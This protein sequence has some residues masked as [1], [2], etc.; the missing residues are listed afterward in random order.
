MTEQPPEFGNLSR[1][2]GAVEVHVLPEGV[3]LLDAA[4]IQPGEQPGDHLV[5]LFACR[6]SPPS[7]IE[8][9]IRGEYPA[10]LSVNSTRKAVPDLWKDQVTELMR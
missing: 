7:I 5:V 2:E 4:L 6:C 9:V 3:N 10:S 1:D 8:N